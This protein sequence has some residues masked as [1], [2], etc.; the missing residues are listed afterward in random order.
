[1]RNLYTFKPQQKFLRHA[2]MIYH[3]A[4]RAIQTLIGSFSPSNKNLSQQNTA[5]VLNQEAINWGQNLS[6]DNKSISEILCYTM[7]Y[8]SLD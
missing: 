8:F 1:M 5:M 6:E 4:K 3:R 2:I 7:L